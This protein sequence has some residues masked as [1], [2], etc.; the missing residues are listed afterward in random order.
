MDIIKKPLQPKQI[1]D[2]V[3]F[4][5]Y[6][7]EFKQNPA[8]C[9]DNRTLT[10]EEFCSQVLKKVKFIQLLNLPARTNIAIFSENSIEVVELF[11]AIPASGNIVITLPSALDKTQLAVMIEKF[12]IKA[13]FTDRKEQLQLQEKKL[14]VFSCMD[15]SEDEAT[16]TPIAPDTP[17]AIF[18]TGGTTGE[19]KGALHTHSS[20]LFA[21]FLSLYLYHDHY[22]ALDGFAYKRVLLSLPLF[23]VM[24]MT[25]CI[26]F[27][28]YSGSYVYVCPDVKNSLTKIPSFKPE[29]LIL[30]PGMVEILLN[31][32]ETN[33]EYLSSVTFII[34]GAAPMNNDYA[35]RAEK[36]GI[37]LALGY[38]LSETSGAL[39]VNFNCDVIPH[40]SGPI[41]GQLK[42]KF[43]NNELW[44]KCPNLML[45]YYKDPELNAESFEDGWFKTG[46]L[47]KLEEYKGRQYLVITGRKKNLII[48]SNGENVS[49]EELDRLLLQHKEVKDCQVKV[50]TV[51]GNEVIGAE[52]I[53]DSEV[54][55]KEVF[56]KIIEDIN[57]NLPSFKQIRTYKLRR[58]EFEKSYAMKKV[59]K[60]T[61]L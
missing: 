49:P 20:V 50:M 33:K 53:P 59:I 36:L 30:V 27:T 41:I 3:S 2:F 56:D 40:A 60:R 21:A 10:Y 32:A 42:C 19:L 38:A 7:Q 4:I 37:K 45:G 26:L 8:L 12:D 39:I 43:V 13:I 25:D 9:D 28:L 48:L 55:G 34:T 24:G 16:L 14:L 5:S 51:N 29:R 15:S 44:I 31:L 58:L 52:I 1:P 6:L 46:D 11:L 57:K 22:G 17:A 18:L 35:A 61:T 23:H 54:E 47:A